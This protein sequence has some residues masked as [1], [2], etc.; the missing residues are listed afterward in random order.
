MSVEYKKKCLS[1]GDET[2]YKGMWARCTYSK[3]KNKVCKKCSQIGKH[4]G[5]KNGLYGKQYNS[6]MRKKLSEKC[7]IS[8]KIAMHRPDVR[9]KHLKALAD[10]K[11]LKCKTDKGQLELLEKWNRLGFQFEPNFQVY[12]GKDLFYIDGYDKKNNIVLEY[13]SKYHNTSFQKKKDIIREKKI[14]DI[15]N[16]KKFWRYN[17]VSNQI[18]NIL[19]Q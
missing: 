18:N 19:N 2:I 9:E 13:D 5:N 10:T 11:Y 12:T 15:L 16:P 4:N 8:I 3:N 7:K 1:C 14:I 6:E 17:V